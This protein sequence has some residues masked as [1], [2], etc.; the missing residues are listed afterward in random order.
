M[1]AGSEIWSLTRIHTSV[2]TSWVLEYHEKAERGSQN[3]TGILGTTTRQSAAVVKT[4]W[5]LCGVRT[6]AGASGST[7]DGLGARGG[8]GARDGQS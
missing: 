5:G 4:G 1:L 6:C 3:R 8:R 2:P 7:A